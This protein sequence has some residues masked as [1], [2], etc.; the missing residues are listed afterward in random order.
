MSESTF[1]KYSDNGNI[2]LFPTD[3]T[4]RWSEFHAVVC[5]YS[6]VH[7]TGAR[8]SKGHRRDDQTARRPEQPG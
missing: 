5:G 3:L 7:V 2:V 4:Q 8:D 6:N 1:E